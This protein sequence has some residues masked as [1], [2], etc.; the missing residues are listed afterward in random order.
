MSVT[1]TCFGVS[2]S[3]LSVCTRHKQRTYTVVKLKVGSSLSGRRSL[4]V[5]NHCLS[6]DKG[7]E[8]EVTS[9]RWPDIILCLLQFQSLLQWGMC[10][11]TVP[12]IFSKLE[13]NKKIIFLSAWQDCH[14]V[15]LCLLCSGG[16][17]LAS[18]GTK[19]WSCSCSQITTM[20]RS[21]SESQRQ[22][23][24]RGF[25]LFCHYKRNYKRIHGLTQ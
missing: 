7:L 15:P 25:F 17:S 24:V 20:E 23:E 1:R 14:L 2:V 10:F 8:Q 16:C 4:L 3:S 5:T 19:Q 6:G 21:W 13:N 12:L 11:D 22:T 18:A 9:L